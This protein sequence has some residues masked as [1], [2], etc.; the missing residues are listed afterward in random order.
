VQGEVP[1]YILD[2]NVKI[3]YLYPSSSPQKHLRRSTD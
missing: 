1:K 3:I 2:A